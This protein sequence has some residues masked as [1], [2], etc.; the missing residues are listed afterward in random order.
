ME[1]GFIDMLSGLRGRGTSRLGS[2]MLN[3]VCQTGADWLRVEH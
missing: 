3:A 1:T 2:A